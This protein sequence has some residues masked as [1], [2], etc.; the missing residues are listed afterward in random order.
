MH[1]DLEAWRWVYPI[2]LDS[3][4]LDVFMKEFGVRGNWGAGGQPGLPVDL[5]NL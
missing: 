2:K 1:S 5:G 3:V 4:S